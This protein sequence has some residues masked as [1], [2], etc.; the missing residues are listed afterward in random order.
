MMKRESGGI[1]VSVADPTQ[2]LS[3]VEITIKGIYKS[4]NSKTINGETVISISLPEGG[5][6]GKTETF[7]LQAEGL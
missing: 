6:A 3:E 4:M 5:E 7:F 1:Q 2:K